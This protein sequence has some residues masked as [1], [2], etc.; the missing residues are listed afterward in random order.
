MLRLPLYLRD[1]VF[2]GHIDPESPLNGVPNGGMA[3]VLAYVAVLGLGVAVLL[4][5]YR[6][7]ER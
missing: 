7:T 5:R 4:H 6:W 1:L 3:A 2:L